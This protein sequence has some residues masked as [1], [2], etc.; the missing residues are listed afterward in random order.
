VQRWHG[1]FD[2]GLYGPAHPLGHDNL[3]FRD[4]LERMAPVFEDPEAQFAYSR[5]LFIGN[6]GVIVPFFVNLHLYRARLDFMHIHNV[7]P[8][9]AI[10]HR[11]SCLEAV[12][13]W[14]D[15]LVE[16]GDWEMWKRISGRIGARA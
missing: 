12:G 14:N 3:Y 13:Y 8:A 16:H 2:G 9:T 15:S 11:R 6:D 7:L 5:P 1:G 10:V 4:H